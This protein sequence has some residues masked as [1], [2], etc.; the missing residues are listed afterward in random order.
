MRRA[1]G[2]DLWALLV[3]LVAMPSATFG[4]GTSGASIVGVVKDSSGG[5]L[6]GVTIEAASPA[7]IER[8]RTT[9]SNEE[10]QYRIVELR[11]GTYT[12]TFSL[13]GFNTF[14]RKDLELTSSFT[15]TVNADLTVGALDETVTVSGQSPL[16]DVTSVT[17]QKTIS[18]ELLDAVPTGRATLGLMALMPAAVSPA[19]VQDV[20]GSKGETSVRM[21]IHGARQ[22]DQRLLQD[23]MSYNWIS[24]ATG[25]SV[26]LNPLGAQE[27]VIDTGSGGSA[28]YQTGGAQVNL[29]PKDG[30]NRFSGTFFAAGTNHSLQ[31]DNFSDDLK[32][33]GLKSV[34]GIRS[35]YDVNAVIAGP[36]IKDKL[37]FMTAHRRWGRRERIAN[38]FHDSNI[39]DWIFTPDLSRPGETAED[40]RSDNIRLTWQAART[41]KFTI[42]EDWQHNNAN[43]QGGGVS[44]GTFAMEAIINPD[45]YCNRV[46]L[47]Q[48]TWTHPRTSNLLFEAGISTLFQYRSFGFDIACGG[49]ATAIG[50][51]DSLTNFNYHGTGTKARDYQTPSNQRFSVSYVT[52]AHNFKVG[53]QVLESLRYETNS[54]RGSDT[55][56]VSYVF[57][58]GTPT[59]L[60]E[61]VTPRQN[62][63]QVGPNLGIFFQDQWRLEKLSLDLGLRYD[64]L[65]AYSPAV[66]QPS[67][68]PFA[69]PTHFDRKDCLPCWHDINP[70]V[71]VA[72]DVF[73]NGTTAV[74]ASIGRYVGLLQN[75]LANTYSPANSVVANT[76]RSWNDLT[77]PVGDPRRGNFFPDC[78]LRNPLLNNECGPMVNRAFGQVQ[79]RTTP[80]SDWI[81][82]FG[83]RDYNWKASVQLDREIRPGVAV[84][85]GYYRTWYG[86]F[87]ATDN[88][89]VTPADYDPYC[90]TAP[91]DARLGDVSGTQICGLYDIKQALFGQVNNVV[92]LAKKFGKQSDVYNGV[93]VN[94]AIRLPRSTTMA[95][96]WNIGNS[97]ATG[98]VAGITFAKANSCFV[99]DSP[100]QLYNCETGNPYQSRIKLNGSIPL[101]G[102][103][104]VAL[105]YQ[106]L[107][108]APYG[109]A[110]TFTS[111]HVA[112]TL[113]RPLAGNT[114]NVTIELLPLGSGY[115]D[116]RINQFDVRLSKILRLAG[117]RIQ[118]N[119]D[120]YNLFNRG[121]VLAVNSTVGPSWLQPTQILDAR[122]I[123][124]GFQVD[125]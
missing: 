104:Q 61:F 28:E 79:V 68:F 113:G 35:M 84:N 95:G 80:D 63:G 45:A 124:F 24:G 83:N 71:G 70:R 62:N 52:G 14:I 108:G 53:V 43:N 12:L 23:G 110:A 86:N 94:F 29:I 10:G 37:W 66:D 3:C 82:G 114:A 67:G 60:T 121:T 4:Q 9:V 89:L 26:Y 122:L 96:G 103:L 5:V 41:H 16:V 18:K 105:V 97:F 30:G 32:D 107:P 73:G 15:A 8:I 56:A 58:G 120:V 65:R 91:T 75:A 44:T 38:L 13:P 87:T 22:A 123:K 109:A 77:F 92:T 72:Y 55:L 115:L 102:Q 93:D 6:P 76:T 50:I 20:G 57:R 21:S 117:R 33:Q 78:D 39:N 100:Q 116:E 112:T 34:N 36:I 25:R 74:K 1:A 17:Q 119:F 90:V 64:Y 98:N 101:P 54:Y 125:F 106:N 46:N 85:V 59:S 11:P 19:G 81:T 47:V 49:I 48:A 69:E 7:L 40:L 51:R 31:G 111:A 27:I 118:A 99:V 2:V 42:S 88:T